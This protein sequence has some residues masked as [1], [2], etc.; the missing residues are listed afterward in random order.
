MLKIM[1]T[2]KF[3]TMFVLGAITIMITIAFV[4]YGIGPQQN[5]SDVVIAQVNKKRITLAEYERAYDMAYRR[6]REIYQNEEEIRKLNL[7]NRVLGELIDNRALMAAAENAGITVTEDELQRAIMNEPAFQR[8]GVFDKGVY[9]RRLRL[10]RTTPRV[11][12]NELKNDLL[13]NKMRRLIGETAEL[14]VDET[15]T[16]DLM[17][18]GNKSQL[19]EIFLS[20][21]KELAVKAYVEGLKRRMKITI[22]KKFIS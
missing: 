17:K 19:T 7:R 14:T 3:F 6:V 9:T 22:N 15:T 2:H 16:L 1:R 20:A 4:F 13:L 12:E 5:P 18:G 21:K 8:E 10:I 11:F